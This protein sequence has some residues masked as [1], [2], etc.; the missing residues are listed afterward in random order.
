M[1]K[2]GRNSM[3]SDQLIQDIKWNSITISE[4]VESGTRLDGSYYD[5]EAKAAKKL[6]Q[7]CKF[8]SIPLLGENGFVKRA[9]FPTRFKRTYVKSGIPF[10]GSSEILQINP[11]PKK[12]LSTSKHKD[13]KELFVEDDW[14]LVSRSGTVGNIAYSTRHF[15]GTAISEHVIRLVP[16][17]YT[18][19]P[20]LYTFLKTDFAQRIL[21]GN[22][23]GSVVNELEPKNFDKLFVPNV[24]EQ[25]KRE[26]GEVINKVNSLRIEIS[27]LL[28]KSNRLF[29]K[30]LGLKPLNLLA[31]KYFN[32]NP[33]EN[34]EIKL[35]DLN[36]RLDASFHSPIIN[37]I[38]KELEKS[39]FEITT[40][41][42]EKISQGMILPGRF[43]RFYVDKEY[44]VPFLGSKEIGQFDLSRIKH[45]SIKNHDR[46]IQKELTLHSNMILISSSGTIG[47]VVIVPPHYEKWTA[48]QH[49]IRIV[50]SK[51]INP[52]YL[53]AFLA[54][55]YGYQLITRYT[56]GS[57]VDEVYD[58]HLA[59]IPIIIPKPHIMNEIGDL[60][61]LANQKLSEA[62]HLER[63]AIKKV[64]D[65]IINN[66][67]S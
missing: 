61:L 19:S 53:Y 18:D 28:D 35:S 32:N 47:N 30:Y 58:D 42:S 17:K 7:N 60:V 6:I 65:L 54:S 15:S 24:P 36:S 67:Y 38:I 22:H 31:P 56:F 25:F 63:N 23:F 13:Q 34:F 12:Y 44:G 37:E 20:Y 48:S 29:Y 50:P 39:E 9:F 41:G 33:I 49:V 52:G 10:L 5:I 1:E 46:R 27:E 11:T 26:I 43:K 62:F 4:V 21:F 64:E 55:D 51:T 14:I 2:K 3:V 8:G 57:V 16:F 66:Q 45:L 59:K 40:V